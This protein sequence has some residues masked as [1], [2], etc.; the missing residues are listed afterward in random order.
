MEVERSCTRRGTAPTADSQFRGVNGST[1]IAITASSCSDG[2][3][4][5]SFWM[6][7]SQ[8]A[9][10]VVARLHT[11]ACGNINTLSWE[12]API[13]PC[14]HACRRYIHAP[15]QCQ[16]GVAEDVQQRCSAGMQED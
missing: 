2:E 4:E 5:C 12:G 14:M 7:A 11:P 9:I 16:K 10:H 1:E 8:D 3:P 6:S 15:Q 13:T